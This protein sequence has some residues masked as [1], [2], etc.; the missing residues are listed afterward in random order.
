MRA[1][2]NRVKTLSARTADR[3]GHTADVI[4]DALFRVTLAKRFRRRGEQQCDNARRL[5]ST[6]ID[7]RGD[8]SLHG[9]VLTADRG[10]GNLSL[11][12][13]LLL[14]GISSILV[15]PQHL[16]RCH[17]FVGRSFLRVTRQ[18]ENE[19]VSDPDKSSDEDI[20]QIGLPEDHA[21][22][23]LST[24]SQRTSTAATAPPP[25]LLTQSNSGNDLEDNSSEDE[26]Y[27]GNDVRMQ[28]DRRRKFV[29]DDSSD[30][31]PAPF[32]P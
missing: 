14:H 18:D 6:F 31:V 7:V 23:L 15:M 3:E 11:I 29:I 24:D 19:G 25:N 16:I 28:I 2:D 9:L 5:I 17:P 21:D 30:A 22:P 1:S 26:S 27:E 4:V 8:N 13:S 10:Y 20:A 32:L 12:R